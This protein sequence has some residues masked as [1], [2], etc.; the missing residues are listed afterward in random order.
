PLSEITFLK[1]GIKEIGYEHILSFRR[2]IYIKHEDIPNLPGSILI[3]TNETNFRIFFTDDTITC[4]TC[5]STGHTSMTCNK[6]TKNI[7]N[8]PQTPN[9]QDNQIHQPTSSEEE[10]SPELLEN[11]QTTESPSFIGED[12]KTHMEWTD[13]ILTPPLKIPALTNPESIHQH[14]TNIESPS[15]LPSTTNQDSSQIKDYNGYFKNR[16]NPGRASGG[17]AIFTKDNIESEEVYLNTHLEAIAVSIK[18]QKQIC[19]CNIYIP[20][21]TP[22]TLHDLSQIISLLPKPFVILGDFNSRNTLWGSS[23]TDKRGKIMERLLERSDLIL[24]NNGKPTRHNPVNDH[25][26]LKKSRAES[27]YILKR[28]KT[29]SW[30]KFTST[31][32]NQTHSTTIWNKIKAFEGIKYQLILK[33]LHYEHDNNLIELSSPRDIAQSFA[34]QFKTNSKLYSELINCTSKSSGPDDIP[35][36]FINNLSEYALTKLLAIY[37]IIWTHETSHKFIPQQYGFRRNHSTQ[38]ALATLHTN[39]SESFKKNHHTILVALDLEKSYGMVWKNRVIDI[40]SSWSIDGNML[41]F[42]H[43]FLS[44]RTIQVKVENTLSDHTTLENGLPQGLVISVTLFL[45]AINDIFNNIQKPVKYTLFSDD[46]NIYC[47]GS[48]TRST[49]ALLQNA[50]NSLVQWSLYS[51][52]KFS[53]HKTQC[54]IFN[55]KKNNTLHHI[56]INNIP[57]VYTDNIRLLGMIFDTK[58]SWAPHLPWQ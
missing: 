54:I 37:N 3:N 52:F 12:P 2:Q 22:L 6:N 44:N 15:I 45:I 23:Y 28:S 48:D 13:E 17:V 7:H 34:N 10:Q 21:S 30:Q 55:K 29:S 36:V 8:T 4:Y 38:D 47:S 18:L 49:V 40:L 32:N 5:K 57:T 24:L 43:N 26:L 33:I 27:K 25:I 46:C 1:A 56:Y 42:L 16:V 9:H 19:I 39:I 53:P 58:F 41:T 14:I 51:G 50:I 20:D 11:I 31:I 35:Y